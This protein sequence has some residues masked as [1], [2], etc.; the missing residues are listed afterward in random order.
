M[1]TRRRSA[2]SGDDDRPTYL[3]KPRVEVAEFLDD[4]IARGRD[5]LG[6]FDVMVFPQQ[7]R[8]DDLSAQ[9][10]AWRNFNKTYLER[11]FTTKEL[12]DW[13]EG[14]VY[15]AVGGSRHMDLGRLRELAQDLRRDINKLVDL[16]ERLPLYEPSEQQSMPSGSAHRTGAAPTAVNMTFDQQQALGTISRAS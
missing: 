4:R 5:L 14:A 10:S 15:F 2:G 6:Q 7:G 13:Y 8:V 12:H 1:P 11:A 3:A 16:R 9:F